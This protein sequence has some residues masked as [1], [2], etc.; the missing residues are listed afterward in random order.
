MI[1]RKLAR[2]D[3]HVSVGIWLTSAY[4]ASPGVRCRSFARNSAALTGRLNK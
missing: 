2:A 1:W 4:E 3:L